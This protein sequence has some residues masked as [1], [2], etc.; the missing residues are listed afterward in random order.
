MICE[1]KDKRVSLVLAVSFLSLTIPFAAAD[2]LAPL[3][4]PRL[5]DEVRRANPELAAA[6]K[7]WE[8]V[9]AKIPLAR[10][11]PAPKIGV[12][13]EE[14]P[15]GTFKINK[16]TAMYQLIQSL[17]FP[18]KLSL[19]Q[20]VAVKEAQIAA[21]GFKRAEWEISS[22]LKN[23]YYDLFMLDREVEIQEAELA[24][25]NQTAA[26]ARARYATGSAPESELLRAQAAVLEASNQLEVLDHRRQAMAAHMNHLLNRPAHAPV[27]RPDP[28]PL[29]PV[30]SSPEDLLA[31][32]QEHQP[33]LLA[34]QFSAERAE[35]AWKLSKRELLPDLETMLELRDPAMGPVGPWDLSLALVLPFWFWTKQQYGVKAALYDKESAQAAYQ[36]MR[37]EVAR[38]VHEHWHE[39]KAAYAT[40]SLCQEGLIPLARQ[41][42]Q[43][44][45]AAYQGGK[46]SIMEV[47]EALK[48]LSERQRSYVEHLVQLE[49]RMVLLEQAAGVPL[50]GEAAF[51]G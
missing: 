37:N 3:S 41:A 43:S 4:L 16:A 12:E 13:W 5:L 15:R 8:A 47:L 26:A 39:A 48:D 38:R 10:G 11:L 32:A 46:G 45:L 1:R 35:A 18:G 23:V 24:W 29:M 25:L 30:P 36:G 6:H 28:I 2:G 34:F 33:D 22:M 49:Q 44:A 27:G 19:R 9:Q 21:M 20:K 40:A 7:R 51:N 14:I 42:V 31:Q 17:P 50:R